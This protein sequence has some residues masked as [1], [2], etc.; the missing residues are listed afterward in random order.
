MKAGFFNKINN[1]TIANF[2]YDF[3]LHKLYD[4]ITITNNVA[5]VLRP[6][7]E[8]RE[9]RLTDDVIKVINGSP[10]IFYASIWAARINYYLGGRTLKGTAKFSKPT[11]ANFVA[12]T[13]KFPASLTES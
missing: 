9:N 12:R 7:V 4:A 3:I 10:K 13:K 8:A 5:K 11:I 2:L 6:S 1:Q